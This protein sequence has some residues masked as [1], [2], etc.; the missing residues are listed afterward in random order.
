M[1]NDVEK[2]SPA[3]RGKPYAHSSEMYEPRVSKG[4]GGHAAKRGTQK[5]MVNGHVWR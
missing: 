3:S 4:G 5:R 1:T 2:T